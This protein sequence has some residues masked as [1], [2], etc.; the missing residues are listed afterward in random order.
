MDETNRERERVGVAMAKLIAARFLA[1]LLVLLGAASR[2]N[3]SA[4]SSA[5]VAKSGPSAPDVAVQVESAGAVYGEVSNRMHASACISEVKRAVEASCGNIERK[6]NDKCTTELASATK[7]CEKTC[8]STT[9]TALTALRVDLETTSRT[10]NETWE[11]LFRSIDVQQ[12]KEA[13]ES[14]AALASQKSSHDAAIKA[15]N[16]KWKV[17]LESAVES[18]RRQD[19]DAKRD[20]LEMAKAS[21]SK[22]ITAMSKQHEDELR[23]AVKLQRENDEKSERAALESLQEA[24]DTA[25]RSLNDTCI[26]LLESAEARRLEGENAKR[27]ALASLTAS[28]DK[29]ISAMSEQHEAQLQSAVAS[30]LLMDAADMRA[31]QESQ[32]ARFDTALRELNETSAAKLESLEH[33]LEATRASR[34]GLLFQLRLTVLAL[35]VVCAVA[36]GLAFQHCSIFRGAAAVSAIF[37]KASVSMGRSLSP[38]VP[39]AQPPSAPQAPP[40]AAQPQSPSSQHVQAV[41]PAGA[42]AMQPAFFSAGTESSVEPHHAFVAGPKEVS[43]SRSRDRV[44]VLVAHHR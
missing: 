36:V 19:E 27:S 40:P 3:S 10:Q 25:L 38:Q 42:S 30:Q 37:S 12:Q 16:D 43:S 18:Q 2:K 39:L 7:A 1:L 17:D 22:A 33:H 32:Q 9:R 6:L 23:S 41:A 4:S 44:Y 28:H 11:A 31:A 5:K 29:A 13:Q 8:D 21:H 24:H 15:L 20:A 14:R 34:D 26:A 35:V